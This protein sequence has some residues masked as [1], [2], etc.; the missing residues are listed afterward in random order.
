MDKIIQ[1]MIDKHPL[2]LFSPVSQF[3]SN[4]LLEFYNDT[5]ILFN[6]SIS[7]ENQVHNVTKLY[8]HA[9]LLVLGCY[10]VLRTMAGANGCFTP[11]IKKEI[12]TLKRSFADIRIPMTKQEQR[13]KNGIFNPN[14]VS[15]HGVDIKGKDFIFEVKGNQVHVLQLIDSFFTLINSIGKNDILNHLRNSGD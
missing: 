2:L 3:Q 9:W 12:L 7:D 6:E 8:T 5:R 11:E 15:I 13:G 10:E 4:Y 14:G 1:D